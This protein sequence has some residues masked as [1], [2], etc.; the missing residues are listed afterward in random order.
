MYFMLSIDCNCIRFHYYLTVL[1]RE[2]VLT[3]TVIV[4]KGVLTSWG[5]GPFRAARAGVTPKYTVG[6]E[7]GPCEMTVW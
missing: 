3:G 4:V 7:V 6:A 5:S 2:A 1:S